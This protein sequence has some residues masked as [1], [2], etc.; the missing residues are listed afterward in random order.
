MYS[1]VKSSSDWI[2]WTQE[3]QVWYTLS[4]TSKC[5]CYPKT[6]SYTKLTMDNG[7]YQSTKNEFTK[8][9]SI[10]EVLKCYTNES[11][12]AWWTPLLG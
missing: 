5:K 11:F 3:Q 10:T 4:F 12:D 9:V 2:L 1:I 6:R 8:S 7:F